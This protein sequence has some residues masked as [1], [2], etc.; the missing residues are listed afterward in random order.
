MNIMILF[1]RPQKRLIWGPLS[2]TPSCDDNYGVDYC[3][4]LTLQSS[5][6][7]LVIGNS[8]GRLHHCI[9]V[10]K[11]KDECDLNINELSLVRI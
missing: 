8:S 2:M 3:S 11:D 4:L 9:V 10:E 7:V 1:F 5:P 6:P